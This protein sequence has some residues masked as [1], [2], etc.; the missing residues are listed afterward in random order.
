MTT[1]EQ[2]RLLKAFQSKTALAGAGVILVEGSSAVTLRSPGSAPP[3]ICVILQQLDETKSYWSERALQTDHALHVPKV[4]IP[5]SNASYVRLVYGTHAAFVGGVGA[6]GPTVTAAL[7]GA[8]MALK[9]LT[10]ELESE[11]QMLKLQ[12]AMQRENLVFTSVSNVL[13]TRHDT[14]K[15]SI[16]N[17]R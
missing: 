16:S 13:K 4:G 5:I 12:Q 15:N 3:R 10:Y 11:T 17:V 14:A 6:S 2:S 7:T 9:S 8:S 1:D